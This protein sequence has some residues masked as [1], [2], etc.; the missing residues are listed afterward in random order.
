ML[1]ISTRVSKTLS[2]EAGHRLAGHAGKCKFYHG[3]HYE[4]T[5]TLSG[6]L[7]HLGMVTDFSY[8][9]Q[10]MGAWIRDH[11]DHTMILDKNDQHPASNAIRDFNR[12]LGRPV[13]DTDGPPTAEVISRALLQVVSE[14]YADTPIEV[15]EVQV[16]ESTAN[17]AISTNNEEVC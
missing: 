3:H 9:D 1:K 4:A 11:L 5:I 15:F 10:G 12:D 16:R 14:M 7:D 8:I 17:F 6:E 2:W 13:F